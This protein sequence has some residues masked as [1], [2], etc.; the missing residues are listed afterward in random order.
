ML[1]TQVEEV[2]IELGPRDSVRYKKGLRQDLP[3]AGLSYGQ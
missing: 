3:A 2:D 1:A